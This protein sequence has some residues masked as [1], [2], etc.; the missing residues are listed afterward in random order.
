MSKQKTK[1]SANLN[2]TS[3][4]LSRSK[5]GLPSLQKALAKVY[6]SS[7]GG[8]PASK[9]MK[10][11]EEKTIV[12][13]DKGLSE[14]TIDILCK[15]FATKEA[16]TC[17]E[18]LILTKQL[19]EKSIGGQ[20]KDKK[21]VV[22][23]KKDP[24]ANNSNPN[25]L[26]NQLNQNS[27]QAKKGALMKAICRFIANSTSLRV[28][29]IN[30]IR[31]SLDSLPLIGQA[32]NDNTKGS[33]RWLSI[34]S[35]NIGDEGLKSLTPFICRT[36]LQVLLLDDV[37]LSDESSKY[38]CSILKANEAKMDSLIFQASLRD[39]TDEYT[40]KSSNSS[41]AANTSKDN[42]FLADEAKSVYGK[43]LLAIGLPNNKIT[44]MGIASI[45]RQLKRDSFLCGF[46][47]RSNAITTDGMTRLIDAL[48]ANN[49]MGMLMHGNVG[50]SAELCSLLA[51]KM[52][53]RS[54][55][56]SRK[57][58]LL[59]AH[60]AAILKRF[61]KFQVMH[62]V[63]FALAPK[64]DLQNETNYVTNVALHSSPAEDFSDGVDNDSFQ[65]L[66]IVN[67]SEGPAGSQDPLEKCIPT[68]ITANDDF[69]GSFGSSPNGSFGTGSPSTDRCIEN[70][71]PSRMSI[72]PRSVGELDSHT[73]S[74]PPAPH[75]TSSVL[76]ARPK[77]R[78]VSASVSFASTIRKRGTMSA[79][80]TS[81]SVTSLAPPKASALNGSTLSARPVALV[82][83]PKS[84]PVKAAARGTSSPNRKVVAAPGDSPAVK[85]LANSVN[86]IT[87]SLESLSSQLRNVTDTLSSLNSKP[88]KV[89][90]RK[91]AA[92]SASDANVGDEED[93]LDAQIKAQLRSK[94]Q[95]LM[96]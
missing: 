85:R 53:N 18:T 75:F 51:D 34:K 87:K 8:K 80:L 91:V 69:N 60:I 39:Y 49:V 90:P 64:T 29:N 56:N 78:G 17:L 89:S 94:L 68:T 43:G 23:E 50:F 7:T 35:C 1:K 20:L 41:A 12:V 27:L 86:V 36:S 33:L 28:M 44:D 62:E 59:P 40:G 73:R 81:K 21:E 14:E 65:T 95:S 71:P 63:C 2:D 45:A 47:I 37:G 52:C 96:E 22:K 84:L 58:D 67:S 79:G 55:Q 3:E 54:F 77:S 70:R 10:D 66:D 46:D 5:L 31:V 4:L 30:S 15:F 83:A 72:R 57:L 38:I 25:I 48:R 32:M 76:A 16:L 13:Q 93:V 26:R 74:S 61:M 24:R 6:A 19:S 9:M 88:L 42:N 82:A 11:L 92:R